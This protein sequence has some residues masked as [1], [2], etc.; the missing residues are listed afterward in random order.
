MEKDKT[1]RG[2]LDPTS[3]PPSNSTG[4]LNDQTHENYD[5]SELKDIVA[6]LMPDGL[7]EDA[8]DKLL[9]EMGND[10][11]GGAVGGGPAGV[12]AAGVS[13][14]TLV[15]NKSINRGL[16]Y[17]DDSDDEDMER[18]LMILAAAESELRE[19]LEM[20]GGFGDR[21]LMMAFEGGDGLGKGSGEEE[22]EVPDWR[23]NFA[24]PRWHYETNLSA[25]LKPMGEN[26]R[27][28]SGEESLKKEAREGTKV[29]VRSSDPPSSVDTIK[30]QR[31]LVDVVEDGDDDCD[32]DEGTVEREDVWGMIAKTA[33]GMAATQSSGKFLWLSRI[34]VT[35]LLS[36]ND[37]WQQTRISWVLPWYIYWPI[38]QV[39]VVLSPNIFY[40]A[41][42]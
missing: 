15:R 1:D 14:N 33:N 8:L 25:A 32:D 9:A 22:R 12:G 37:V 40:T 38:F 42:P 31:S 29:Q 11:V 5:E 19:E 34:S 23:F 27:S 4:P 30:M 36:L 41:H 13:K 7:S 26:S 6:Q 17:E 28:I 2:Y 39:C 10:E 21:M 18:E 35:F 3:L 24:A 20:A 16:A